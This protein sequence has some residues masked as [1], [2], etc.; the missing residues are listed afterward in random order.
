[1]KVGNPV[2]LLCRGVHPPE[3]MIHFVLCFRFPPYFREMSRLCG[4]FSKF[5]LF[6]KIF[7]I[8]ISQNFLWPF[9]NF[10]SYFPCFSIFT[11]FHENFHF[12]Y[13]SKYS[14]SFRKIF[15]FLFTYFMCISFPPYFDHDAFMHHSMHVL[16]ASAPLPLNPGSE[17][18]PS[19]LTLTFC[20][21]DS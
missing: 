4:K 11:L 7:S 17:Y 1:M 13:F 12:P 6:P 16:D 19:I 3:T 20:P 2:S 9:S 14:L 5:Y 21:R 18:S 8:F 10:P 15:V